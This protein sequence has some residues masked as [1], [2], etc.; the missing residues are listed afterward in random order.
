MKCIICHY[1]EI[2]LKG[3]N[4]IFFEKQLVLNI[5]KTLPDALINRLHGKIIV[6][7]D[8]ENVELKLKKVPG[9]EYF[10]FV[11]KS[12]SEKNKI[13]EILLKNIEKE[14]FSTFRVTVKRIDKSFPISSMDMAA[15]MGKE[16]VIN[17][18]KKVNLHNPDLTCF[19]EIDNNET[20]IYFK[21]IKGIG[22]LPTKTGG[23][24]ISLLSGGID[25]P[26]ASFYMI[27]RGV[28]CI[29]LHFHAYPTTS[30]QSIEKVKRITNLLSSFQ[31]ESLLCLI[32][33]DKIQ[34][35]IMINTEEKMR[36]LL[37]RRFMLRIAEKIMKQKKA[38]AII[39]GESLG[40][41]ASQTIEN[42]RVA[43]KAVDALILRPLI[44]FNKS[45]IINQ[46]EEI[47]TYNISIL[48]E[49]DCCVRFLPKKPETK[50]NV[51]KIEKQEEALDIEKLVNEA[52]E[53]ME[54]IV[55][56]SFNEE[57]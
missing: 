52:V 3:K 4:R 56:N 35:E 9:I 19:I 54:E 48:P 51:F 1:S 31:G 25:S 27:K 21:K 32:S 45:E 29:F 5:K 12:P 42:I 17:M 7:S 18:N 26:V 24:M 50:G 20:Y 49:D 43:E 38:K 8:E 37:Y 57:K 28:K 36:V 16:I 55:I 47:E 10:S 11:Q 13:K 6:Y 15:E 41:V 14:N 30:K 22:G 53:G 33:F 46:A 44:G 34:K 23:L 39:T 40:Q 2:A